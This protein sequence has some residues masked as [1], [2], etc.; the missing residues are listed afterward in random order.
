MTKSYLQETKVIDIDGEKIT[1]TTYSYGLQKKITQLTQ[2]EKTIEAMDL[3]I[4]NAIS[5]W[6][7]TDDKGVKLPIDHATIDKLSGS[8]VSKI[9]KEATELNNL[10]DVEIKNLDGR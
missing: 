9:L 8:F 7:L 1:L 6:T 5:D 10:S 4:E 3:F 2:D